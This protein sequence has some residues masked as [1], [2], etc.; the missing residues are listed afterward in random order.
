MM[1]KE[2][3]I[4]E[5]AITK[6]RA[7]VK[8]ESINF[9]RFPDNIKSNIDVML[10]KIDS[11]KSI[12]VALVTCCVKKII[13][14]KQDIRLHRTDFKGGYSA[15]S[16]D[17]AITTPFFK[18]YFPK[19]ANKES[20]FLT[21]ATRERIKWTKKDG[22]ALKIRDKNVKN[23][24]LVL[25][26]GIQRGDIKAEECLVYI[27]AKLILLTKHIDLVFD[28]TIEAIEFSEIININTVI[29]MLE[30]HFEVKLSS[31]LPVI[32]I[33]TVYQ[34]LLSVIK[35]YDGKIL[36]PLNV[37]TSSDKHGFGD[38]EIWN[39]NKTP[40][41]MVEIKHNIPI[42]R[43]MVFDI[44]KKTKNTT[45]QRYYLLTTYDGCFSTPEE[46][47]YINKFILKIKKD[48]GL[49]VI[50]N[51]IIQS[52]KY[53]MRFIEDYVTFIKKYT[54][55]LIEDAKISTEVREFHIKSWQDIL[56]EHEIKY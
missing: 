7:I 24:F 27:F 37:H 1:K 26:D 42:E 5:E 32:A 21:L 52:L 16:L 51:G 18:K 48:E 45:I 17:T 3:E 40:F 15:R 8:S 35:R 9:D 22:V 13:D 4:L 29:K 6:A 50:P 28:E 56:K 54:S 47:N 38:V 23:S 43:N 33:Y 12:L 25:L 49:E 34:M 31:R 55:N 2:N 44:A 20:S 30:K 53:Y 39:A 14:R 41:E 19:Y 36:S 46:E 10:G 11:N